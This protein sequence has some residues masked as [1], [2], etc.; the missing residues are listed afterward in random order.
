MQSVIDITLKEK[1]IYLD[2][3]AAA[4]IVSEV[5]VPVSNY[6]KHITLDIDY[7]AKKAK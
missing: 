4:Q 7:I 3:H 5:A 2:S 6:V 1:I